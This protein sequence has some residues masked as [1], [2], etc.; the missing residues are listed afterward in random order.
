MPTVS[1]WQLQQPVNAIIFDCDGT[2][3]AIEG[4]DHLARLNHVGAAVESLTAEAMGKSG[5]HPEL[6]RKR[7]ELVQPSEKQVLALADDYYANRAPD[8]D[9]I[10][11]LLSRLHKTIYLVS[12][13]VNPAVS[14][15]G[16]GLKI[17]RSNIFAVDLTFDAHGAY[18]DF[19]TSS[20][21]TTREGKSIIAAG[22]L[23]RHDTIA[24]VGDG[25][26]DFVA[27]DVVTRFIGYGGFFCRE[28]LAARCEFY[29]R[30]QSF[31]ALLPL[32]LTQHEVQSLSAAEQ[33][34]YR[35]GLA[36]N[37]SI[38]L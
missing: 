18:K 4:I 22:L 19:D 11:Q 14:N 27:Y 2:L 24:L 31:A 9:A 17:P 10:I 3:S 20:P 33:A 36:A 29:I 16:S 7:L 8:S 23:A 12:S 21:L 38:C 25:M 5:I 32:L 1:S 37:S 26:N 34:L 13:G 28:N 6:Y 35:S 15:F 30:T